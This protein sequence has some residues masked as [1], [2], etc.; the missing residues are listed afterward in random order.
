MLVIKNKIWLWWENVW[1]DGEKKTI[2]R[3]GK[4]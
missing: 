1:N 3:H 2:I 4:R